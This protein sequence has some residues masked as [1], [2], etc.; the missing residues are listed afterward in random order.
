MSLNA[1]SNQLYALFSAMANR[2]NPNSH[3]VLNAV[4][5]YNAFLDIKNERPDLINVLP[6]DIKD[7]FKNGL[8]QDLFNQMDPLGVADG[9]INQEEF[10]K[11]L[12]T[13]TAED[14]PN[15][16]L[17]SQ[18]RGDWSKDPMIRG[19]YTVQNASGKYNTQLTAQNVIG[20]FENILQG[21]Q[22]NIINGNVN[23]AELQKIV[24]KYAAAGQE[25]RRQTAEYILDYYDGFKN[26]NGDVDVASL[27]AGLKNPFL[28]SETNWE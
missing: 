11:G 22:G 15:L 21:E 1:T 2:I 23:K 10:T 13:G 28:N 18:K 7:K 27:A 20:D 17:G 3:G 24:A 8:T 6:Q 4:D 25:A 14:D 9:L 19:G 26:K 5:A 16:K 12:E